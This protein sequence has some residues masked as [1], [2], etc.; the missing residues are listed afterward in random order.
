M[1]SFVSLLFHEP[2]FLSEHLSTNVSSPTEGEDVTITCDLL[3]TNDGKHDA[4]WSKDSLPVKF[5]KRVDSAHKEKHHTLKIEQSNIYDS[6]EYS[7]DVDGRKR[8]LQ[9]D[10]K[11]NNHLEFLT[12]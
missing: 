2:A 5:T 4:K 3:Q 7:I 6:G 10:V 9:L 8:S 1:L 11:R 12:K